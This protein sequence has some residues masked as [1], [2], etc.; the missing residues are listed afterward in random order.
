MKSCSCWDFARV[1]LFNLDPEGVFI[2]SKEE[3]IPA[4]VEN[5]RENL[6]LFML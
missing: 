4:S 1:Y 5:S 3:Y 2:S 6:F